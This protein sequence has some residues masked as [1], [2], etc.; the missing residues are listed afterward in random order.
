MKKFLIIATALLAGTA[1]AQTAPVAQPAPAVPPAS[2]APAAHPMRDKVMTRA[3]AVQMVRQHFGEVDSNRDGTATAAEIDAARTKRF[4]DFKGF[5]G[6][7]AMVMGDPN[8]A[9]DRLDANKDGSI[10][11]DEF[12]KAREQRVERRIVKREERKSSPKASR[13][14]RRHVMRMH[15]PGGFGGGMI[16]MA[17][18]NKDGQVTQA[19]AEAMALQHFDQMD[20]NRDGQVTP[21]ER[22]AGR[23]MM[24]KRT[25]EEKKSGS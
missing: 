11:R 24:F 1:V 23:Q 25:F 14:V 2:P 21:E 12:T 19:E 4:E 18:T 20:T 10:S 13:D 6:G 3:E 9:F 5:D 16:A 17:D 8:V 15:G 7:H 22:R